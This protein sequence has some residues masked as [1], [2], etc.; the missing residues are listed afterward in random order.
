[1]TYIELSQRDIFVVLHQV[2]K[3]IKALRELKGLSQDYVAKRLGI[4]QSSY[5]RFENESKRIDYR[6]IEGVADVFEVTPATIIN[7]HDNQKYLLDSSP[8]MVREST[9]AYLNYDKDRLLL[10]ERIKHLEQVRD[11]LEKQLK[12]KDEIIRLLKGD[13][14]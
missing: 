2:L 10:E 5:A 11:L 12:D 9:E 3:N 14:G 8:E 7:F 4:S 6:L 1:M 13:E